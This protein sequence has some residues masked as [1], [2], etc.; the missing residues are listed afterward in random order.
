[1]AKKTIPQKVKKAIQDY[2]QYLKKEGLPIEKVILYGSY[3][4]GK[5]HRWSDVDICIISSGFKKGMNPLVYL[6]T[7]KRDKDIEAMIAPVGFH[8]RDFVDESPLV[9]EIKKTGIKVL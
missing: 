8:P 5:T 4:K 9:W 2:I 1:M 3:A 6:W 7:K